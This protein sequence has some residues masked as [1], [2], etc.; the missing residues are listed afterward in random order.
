MYSRNNEGK[1]TAAEAFIR[2]FR[3][4]IYKYMTSISR[5]VYIDKLNEIIEKYNNTYHRTIK[6]KPLDVNPSINFDFNQENNKEDPKVKVGANV[7]IPKSKNIFGK[8]FVPNW[9]EEVF[10][11]KKVKNTIPR[12]YVISNLNCEEI[13]QAF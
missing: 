3:N 2:T 5:N 11:I 8:S 9:F 13:V 6:M 7:R 12:A 10:V 4:E 1:Y